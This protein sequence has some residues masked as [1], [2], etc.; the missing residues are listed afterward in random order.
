MKQPY[1]MTREEWLGEREKCQIA[2]GQQNLTRLS[3]SED[4]ARTGR[5][6]FLMFGIGKYIYDK[7]VKGEEWALEALEYGRSAYDPYE[8]IM[9]KAKEEGLV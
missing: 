3:V 1:E 9:M 7:A 5:L 2:H 4:I 6:E 8:V